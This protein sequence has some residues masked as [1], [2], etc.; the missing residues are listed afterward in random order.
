MTTMTKSLWTAIPVALA[1]TLAGSTTRAGETKAGEKKT[2]L[3]ISPHT[4][5]ECLS[6][7]DNLAA[8]KQL[9]RFE[10]G[11]MH[12]DHTG[13]AK[14]QAESEEAALANVPEPERSKAR[15]IQLTKFTPAQVKA[16]HESKK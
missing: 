16:A 8:K 14:V 12:G 11:C 13:Y 9:E 1:L 2:Y 7:L 10:F 6:A 5:E 4:A 15:A 3:V